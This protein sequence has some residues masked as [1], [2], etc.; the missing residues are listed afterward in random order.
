V[1]AFTPLVV[2]MVLVLFVKFITGFGSTRTV[3]FLLEFP[4]VMSG[5]V[6]LA[7]TVMLY[8]SGDSCSRWQKR[9]LSRS[10]QEPW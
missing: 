2:V 7:K 4:G 10:E 3:T 6:Q 8:S 1:L 5:F 9:S